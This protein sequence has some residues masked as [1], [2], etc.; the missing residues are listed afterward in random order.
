MRNQNIFEAPPIFDIIPQD[1]PFVHIYFLGFF[2]FSKKIQNKHRFFPKI[3]QNFYY[4][5]DSPLLR[6]A[7]QPSTKRAVR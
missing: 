2:D 7:D 3:N 1:I 6:P 4:P 5:S